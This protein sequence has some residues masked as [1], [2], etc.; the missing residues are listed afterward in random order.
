M[1]WCCKRCTELCSCYMRYCD[2][3]ACDPLLHAIFGKFGSRNCPSASVWPIDQGVT[4]TGLL[5]GSRELL[6][7]FGRISR[8]LVSCSSLSELGLPGESVSYQMQLESVGWWSNII[9]SP[10]KTGEFFRGA[11]HVTSPS[12]H[13]GARHVKSLPLTGAGARHVTLWPLDR[14]STHPSLPPTR[15]QCP[16]CGY[17]SASFYLRRFSPLFLF[18]RRG[19]L[20]SPIHRIRHALTLTH[21]RPVPNG[22]H[23]EST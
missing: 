16:L 6:C 3:A 14:G 17:P 2:C 5:L 22:S 18:R 15:V 21:I 9:L 4:D 19:F 8:S 23:G 12:R 20:T 11:R 13:P 7:L 10:R 1:R